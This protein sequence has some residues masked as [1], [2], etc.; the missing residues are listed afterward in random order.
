MRDF[1]AL[2]YRPAKILSELFPAILDRIKT[3]KYAKRINLII[4]RAH[5]RKHLA[6]HDPMTLGL[7]FREQ[8]PAMNF[9]TKIPQ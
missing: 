3:G 7:K 9:R 1:G 6:I 2:S 5:T 4:F 8:N